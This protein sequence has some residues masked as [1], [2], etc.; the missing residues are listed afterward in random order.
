[1]EKYREE[2]SYTKKPEEYPCSFDTLID[3]ITQ[4]VSD[5]Q[6]QNRFID[7]VLSPSKYL[8]TLPEIY[9]ENPELKVPKRLKR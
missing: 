3:N 2:T 6:K 8:D 4:I 7:F 1:M 5:I 9:K